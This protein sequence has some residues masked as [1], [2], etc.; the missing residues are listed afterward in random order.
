LLT[1]T[2]D[3]L[4]PQEASP[5]PTQ[6][7]VPYALRFMVVACVHLAAIK[8]ALFAAV[9]QGNVAAIWPP[10][11]IAIAALI[12]W[13]NNLWP[14]VFASSLGATLATGVPVGA[15]AGMAAANAAEA[16]FASALL[17]RVGF[18]SSLARARDIW[19]LIAIG[20]LAA[21]AVSAS[22][23]VSA[24]HI[25]GI[26]PQDRLAS[27]WGVWWLS[28]AMGT[29]TVAPPI[30]V[31]ARRAKTLLSPLQRTELVAL[32]TTATV[33]AVFVFSRWFEPWRDVTE[34]AF[35]LFP[36]V[37]WA[38]ARFGQAHSVTLIFLFSMIGIWGTARGQGPFAMSHMIDSLLLLQSFLAVLAVSGLFL[39]AFADQGRRA[40]RELNR[41]L[42]ERKRAEAAAKASE[43]RFRD[44]TELS[45]DWYWEQDAELRFVQFSGA[46]WTDQ[47]P[48]R[49]LE[50]KR[51]WEVPNHNTEEEW[52]EHR[53]VLEAHEPFRDFLV[54]RPLPSGEVRHL[55]VSGIPLFGDNGE[56]KGY[57][58]VGVDIT[59]Q[60][61]REER[62]KYLAFYDALT[63]LPNRA[64]ITDRLERLLVTAKRAK[65]SVAVLFLDLDLFK[66]V[67]DTFGHGAGDMVLVETGQRLAQALRGGDSLGR[68]GGDEFLALQAEVD[69]LAD[70]TTVA[71]RLVAAVERPFRVFDREVYLTVSIGVSVFP[72]DGED[73]GTLAKHADIAMYHA[74]TA[75]R[76]AVRFFEKSMS[77]KIG[78]RLAIESGLRRA[79]ERDELELHFQPIVSLA[80][81]EIVQVEALLRWRDP[82]RG[83]V[84]PDE[85]IPVAEE[86]GLI[87]AIGTWVLNDAARNCKRWR[88]AGFADLR[89]AVNLSAHQFQRTDVARDVRESLERAQLEASALELEVT[90]S[91]F[92]G[93]S[94]ENQAAI[95]ALASLG[96]S[97]CVDDFGT[98]YS[99]LGQLRS[100][101]PDH[102]KIDRVFLRDL[103]GR[104]G[105]TRIV[106]GIIALAHNLG[107][108][109]TAEGV[110]MPQQ[111]SIINEAGCDLAQGTL[112]SGALPYDALMA[113]LANWRAQGARDVGE[114]A[115]EQLAFGSF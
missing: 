65:Q 48:A 54:R 46:P 74:K 88:A 27:L 21:P 39:S 85:F 66:Q 40:I 97:L 113:F 5:T 60:I 28:D 44:L 114:Q 35:V 42:D 112:Y 41:E 76:N 30:L 24:L 67:N 59:D 80:T 20:A 36:F 95:N 17:G 10:T 2:Q 14:A 3:A 82:V 83:F 100:I 64:L 16:L 1:Q 69:S 45:S 7:G 94:V 89:V 9:L 26:A 70:V 22:L 102:I 110:E 12:L 18:Q 81:R 4:A 50:G 62:I 55:K 53:A 105:N 11:G 73:A 52:R 49:E 37:V 77:S 78:R 93:P 6:G 79:L 47:Y 84:L 63:G 101:R 96:V 104:S 86:S 107:I 72:N 75:G 51:R 115:Q 8:G 56:F 19:A 108:K 61:E 43:E 91:G 38:A 31:W 109:V 106:K 99:N 111:E 71:Q 23:G 58:G 29:L 98:G 25:A 32:L 90:E 103:E 68:L 92:L 15:C 33:C 87:A 13:G 34:A 57:R